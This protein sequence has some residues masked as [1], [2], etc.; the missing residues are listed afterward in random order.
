MNLVHSLLDVFQ[1]LL[2]NVFGG[3]SGLMVCDCGDAMLVGVFR[4]LATFDPPVV[5]E[6]VGGLSASPE[7]ADVLFF[8][9]EWPNLSG[10]G[11]GIIR[12]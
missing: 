7:M 1:S 2:F 5:D 6:I 4:P 3:V 9:S 8:E 11:C 10:S 12:L